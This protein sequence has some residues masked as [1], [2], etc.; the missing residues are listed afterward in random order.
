MVVE[1]SRSNRRAIAE[2]SLDGIEMGVTSSEVIVL[3]SYHTLVGSLPRAD[4]TRRRRPD[5]SLS[6]SLSRLGV[7]GAGGAC[8]GEL[9]L[10]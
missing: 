7:F 1:Q 5:V 6:L 2:P 4:C 8:T 9:H 3:C 10:K